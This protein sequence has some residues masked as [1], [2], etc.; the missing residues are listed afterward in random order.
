M[1]ADLSSVSVETT[2]SGLKRL[3]IGNQ[4]ATATLY[5]QGAH[6][7]TYRPRNQPDLLWVSD[8]EDYQP[9]KAIRGG[10][11]I[12]WPWFGAH[13]ELA[14][15][16]SHGL[17]RTAEWDHEIVREAA[18]QT[19]IRLSFA[20]D[21]SEPGFP[22]RA[23]VELDVSVGSSLRLRMTT[24][25]EDDSTL[26]LSEALHSYFPVRNMDELT[27]TGLAG[28][29]YHDKLSGERARWPRVFRV[30]QEIDRVLIDQGGVIRLKQ[31][32]GPNI[33]IERQ[34]SR[35]LVVW[36]PWIEKSR[37]LSNFN[38]TDYQNMICL[39]SANVLDD[40][41]TLAPGSSHCLATQISPFTEPSHA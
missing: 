25:N 24:Y 8:A 33:E 13:P 3:A 2:P 19:D 22:Y 37:T 1:I 14:G 10:I 35:S 26:P 16:P 31:T 9:G 21:G 40:A 32:E 11:P 23:R 5:L 27:V 20:T 12:C 36:N 18:M 4:A 28:H 6:L 17:A 41:R 34:G 38:D 15:A 29:E 39:E 7:T 30:D